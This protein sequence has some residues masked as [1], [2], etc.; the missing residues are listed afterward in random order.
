[1]IPRIRKV[2]IRTT[3]Q[4]VLRTLPPTVK[5]A[6]GILFLAYLLPEV[7]SFIQDHWPHWA[8]GRVNWFLCPGFHLKKDIQRVWMLSYFSTDLK[9]WLV[10]YLFARIAKMYSLVLFWALFLFVCFNTIDILMFWWNFKLYHRIYID[11]L[12]TLLILM[13][14]IF[15]IV[16][17]KTIGGVKSLF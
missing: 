15:K 16:G 11:L 13:S 2:R 6:I 10:T 5:W 12:V 1:V 4:T 7:P 8:E 3:I 14:D 17:P 9:I